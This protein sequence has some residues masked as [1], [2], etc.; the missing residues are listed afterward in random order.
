[1][2][3]L[4][5]LFAYLT[6][7][8]ALFA[9]S[10]NAPR[11]DGFRDL[12]FTKTTSKDAIDML[13]QPAADKVDALDISKVGRWLDAKHKEKIFRQLTFQKVGDFRTIKLSFLDDKLMMIELEFGK[14][15]KPEKLRNIFGV[16]FAIVGGPSDLPDKPGQYPPPFF[17]THYPDSFTLV[18]ISD[19][20]F[21][22]ANCSA[23]TG[24][25]TG[26]DRVRLVTRTLEKK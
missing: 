22:W 11:S 1:M 13:G 8:A 3:S 9:Q 10:N 16:Q 15:V 23:S 25:P 21:M 7:A 4:L 26:V 2:K 6:F 20:A 12:I 5:L 19:Q 17:A 14:N 24:V 18:G